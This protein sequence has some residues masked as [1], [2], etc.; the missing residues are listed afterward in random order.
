MNLESI[1][2]EI[3]LI[4]EANTKVVELG[5]ANAVDASYLEEIECNSSIWHDIEHH[6]GSRAVSK[7]SA[8]KPNLDVRNETK[9]NAND[10]KK[11]KNVIGNMECTLN[12]YNNIPSVI[13][14]SKE[15]LKKEINQV[16]KCSNH[17]QYQRDK[18]D[19]RETYDRLKQEVC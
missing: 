4:D 1:I 2:Q 14:E 19:D 3:S 5:N 7:E 15:I 11:M 16:E 18:V 17:G 12:H 9:A 6:R 8:D 10:I 13:F